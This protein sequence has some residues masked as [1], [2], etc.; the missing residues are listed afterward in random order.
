M[1][2]HTS[3][4]SPAGNHRMLPPPVGIATPSLPHRCGEVLAPPPCEAGVPCLG[5][6]WTT[7]GHT[8]AQPASVVTMLGKRACVGQS[9]LS[10]PK[11]TIGWVAMAFWPGQG[12]RPLDHRGLDL[13]L[14]SAQ[15]P[16]NPFSN[17]DSFKYP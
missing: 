15:Q 9:R 12:N 13:G 16:V 10:R 7:G 1:E 11:S 4:P 17:F 2:I 6:R 8:T 5:R 3:L 14:D